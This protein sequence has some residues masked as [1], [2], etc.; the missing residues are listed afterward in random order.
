MKKYVIIGNGAA[1]VGAIEGIRSVDKEGGITVISREPCHVYA[2]PLISYLLQGKTD[3]KR[4][5]YRPESFYEDNGVKVMYGRAA[6]K[7]DPE[8]KKVKLD[9]GEEVNYDKLLSACGSDPFVPAFEGIETVKNRFGFMT[10]SDAE[11]LEKELSEDKSVLIMGAGLIGLKC[12][13]GIAERVGKITVCDLAPRVLSSILDADCAS[14]MQERLE[15]EGI[16]FLL[17]DTAVRFDGNKAYMKSGKEVS[18]DILITA[19]GV[20]ANISLLKEAGADCGRGIVTDEKMQT[21]LKD[22]YAAGDCAESVDSTSG[23]R[24]VMAIM[25]LAY[26]QG[27]CAGVNMAGGEE[28]IDNAMP[29][30]SIGFFGL[31]CMSAGTYEGECYE[32]KGEGYIK[33]LYTKDNLLKGFILIGKNARAGIY[34]AMIRNKTPLDSVDFET[35]KKTPSLAPMGKSYRTEKLGGVV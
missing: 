10:L 7:I 16:E 31:H 24:K 1:A 14:L 21:S 26:M 32:E 8:G 12:A 11:A 2:R 35:L 33:R 23:Q 18:F 22:I 17:D 3:K 25:P 19:V 27:R 28:I 4:M 13:E 30:N 5:L 9:S 15:K 29:M 6:V 34:T 20:R